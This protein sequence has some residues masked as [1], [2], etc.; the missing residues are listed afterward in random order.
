MRG[1]LIKQ[2]DW[3]SSAPLGDK[4][5]VC[6]DDAQQQR[7]LLASRTICRRL[8]FGKMRYNQIGAVRA[9]KG[10]PSRSVAPFTC[11][12]F[13][14]GFTRTSVLLRAIVNSRA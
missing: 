13:A 2:Q 3:P 11:A 5:C 9:R 8:R 7:L 6:E 1:N 14:P 12:V 4:F 10:P